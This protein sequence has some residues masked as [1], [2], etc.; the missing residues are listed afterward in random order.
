MSLTSTY[1]VWEYFPWHAINNY[2]HLPHVTAIV[3]LVHY[4]NAHSQTPPPPNARERNFP[5]FSKLLMPF[6]YIWTSVCKGWN[7]ILYSL[8]LYECSTHT[9]AHIYIV[10][11]FRQRS[12]LMGSCYLI[13]YFFFFCLTL[14]TKSLFIGISNNFLLFFRTHFSRAPLA[15]QRQYAFG[16]TQN[17]KRN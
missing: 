2:N 9:P 7:G 1:N 17:N 11:A 16:G 4:Y 10:W 15:N 6:E 5:F 13:F 3:L 14:S 12:S 8:S